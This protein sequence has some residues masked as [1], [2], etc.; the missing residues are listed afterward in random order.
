MKEAVNYYQKLYE[1]S[2]AF[3]KRKVLREQKKKEI[4]YFLEKVNYKW[5]L[6]NYK[7]KLIKRE[8]IS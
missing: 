4:N 5:I 2:M 1:C 3:S 6:N 7:K 8:G